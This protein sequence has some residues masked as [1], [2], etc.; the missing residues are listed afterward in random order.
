MSLKTSEASKAATLDLDGLGRWLVD[1]GMQGLP[2]DEQLAG[3]CQQIYEAG[4]PMK[5][6][7]MGMGTLHPRYG[8]HTFLWRPGAGAI[9]YTPRERSVMSRQEYLRSPV[10]YMRSRGLTAL[11]RRIDSN[12]PEEFPIFEDLRKEGLI[13]YAAWIIPYR[14]ADRE[15]MAEGARKHDLPP[16]HG[17]A[18]DGVFFSCASD[19]PEGFDE[20]HL[21]QLGETLPYLALAVKSRL[22]Y[23]VASTVI[24]TYLGKDAGHRVLTGAIERGTAEAIR[25]VIWF[26]DLRGF[27]RLTDSLPRD[28]LMET[29]D[30]YLE[31]M[32]RPVHENHGQILKF[33]GDGL[34][35]TFNLTGRD[36]ATVCRDALTAAAQLRDS[37]PI[38]ND[39]R[40]S[41]GKPV[42]DFGL[43]LHLGEV[44]YGNIGASE[45]LDFTV[46]GPAVNEASRV[47]AL[48]RPLN[49]NVLISST[50]RDSAGESATDLVS[51]GFHAL[52]G[53]REPHELFTLAT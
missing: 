45:R 3:F 21:I 47:Q 23:D 46:V 13:D 52:R 9:E 35:A 18:L 53:V 10:Y 29:L 25:A 26:S 15:A 31:A 50:L 4:F 48:C 40:R 42:M 51:L 22:T 19:R 2:L 41:A 49:R 36:E 8:A 37:F 30:D 39:A 20:G 33:M 16:V 7:M 14:P 5:R 1:R 43:A 27:T 6:A 24:E 44:L 38:F 17:Q 32:A 28:V 11:R 34:L 12:E